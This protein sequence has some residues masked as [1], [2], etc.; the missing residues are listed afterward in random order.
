MAMVG[1]L[2]VRFNRIASASYGYSNIVVAAPSMLCQGSCHLHPPPLHATV[3]WGFFLPWNEE[4]TFTA[5]RTNINVPPLVCLT[6]EDC[7]C[8][9][10]HYRAC[11]L[12]SP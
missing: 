6:T 1:T 2:Y 9:S 8:H 7:F 12:R 3:S 4:G 10:Q 11:Y 5:V